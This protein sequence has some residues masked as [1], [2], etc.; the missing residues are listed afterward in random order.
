MKPWPESKGNASKEKLFH[1]QGNASP[2]DLLP[3]LDKLPA[4]IFQAMHN[5]H[6]GIAKT[7]IRRILILGSHKHCGDTEGNELSGTGQEREL[8]DGH[9][10]SSSGNT[11]GDGRNVRAAQQAIDFCKGLAERPD[12]SVTKLLE[13]TLH[14]HSQAKRQKRKK[15][16]LQKAKNQVLR[17]PDIEFLLVL[18]RNV[19]RRT[20][21]CPRTE[22]L[23]IRLLYHQW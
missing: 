16:E 20:E 12:A 11:S 5:L 13:T 17:N 22:L 19:R 8:S 23:F 7:H 2:L 6:L 15:K 10:S 21:T 14:A 9:E 18:N 4:A 3:Y 1:V